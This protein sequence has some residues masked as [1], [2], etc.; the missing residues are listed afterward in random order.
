MA[1]ACRKPRCQ[2]LGRTGGLQQQRG[3]TNGLRRFCSPSLRKVLRGALGDAETTSIGHIHAHG[4]RTQEC[5]R[6]GARAIAD[7]FGPP[8]QQPPVT[9]A[10]GHIGNLG[11]GGGMVESVVSSRS[12]GGELFAI[13]NLDQL[14]DASPINACSGVE[15]AG[16]PFININITPQG[17]ATAIRIHKMWPLIRRCGPEMGKMA[18]PAGS[19]PS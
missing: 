13:Q 14:K 6:C 18:V 19:R 7:V 1:G 16:D 11:A 15:P 2:H 17:Q 4:L 8:D 10:K 9:T 12:L 5:D 3:G